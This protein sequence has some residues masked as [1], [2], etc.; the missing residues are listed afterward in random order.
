MAGKGAYESGILD[1]IRRMVQSGELPTGD[2]CAVSH[3][4]TADTIDLEILV[5]KF[6][7]NEEG[8]DRIALLLFGLW[9][10]LYLALFRRTTVEEE[11]ASSL[12]VPL[13]VAA[14]YHRKVRGMSQRRLRRLLRSV[15]VYATLLD[16]NPHSRVSAVGGPP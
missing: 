5:P 3:A 7:K 4:P 13:R 16:E 6:F 10:I 1:T 8:R 14:R 15:P 9:G 11:G 12:R 2:M